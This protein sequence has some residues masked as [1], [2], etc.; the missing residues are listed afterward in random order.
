M[1]VSANQQSDGVVLIIDDNYTGVARLGETHS[2]VSTNTHELPEPT[3]IGP[4]VP[5][6]DL[7]S[8]GTNGPSPEISCAADLENA[9]VHLVPET[10]RPRKNLAAGG[11]Q[12][13]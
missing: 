13:V 7:H 3:G 4:V 12:S 9:F 10:A 11:G 6:A 5:D 1:D 2:A 8:E